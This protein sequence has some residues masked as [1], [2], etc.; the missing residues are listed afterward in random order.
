MGKYC[1]KK[2]K[3]EQHIRLQA[4]LAKIFNKVCPA[5]ILQNNRIAKL[6]GLNIYEISSTGT[7]NKD[8]N[9]EVPDGKNNENIFKPCVLTQIIF[10]PTKTEKLKNKVTTKWLVTVKLYGI[11]PIKFRET[12]KKNKEKINGKKSSALFPRILS[13]TIFNK[14]KKK[15]S[16]NNWKR[17]GTI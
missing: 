6:K 1:K 15:N 10:I 8:N 9:T 12:I 16:I 7:N 5:T 17:V 14:V 3:P 2:I 11:N 4:K 13:V